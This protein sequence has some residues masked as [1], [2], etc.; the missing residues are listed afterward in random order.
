MTAIDASTRDDA[1]VALARTGDEA[2]F[3]ALM[4]RYKGRV[5]R[6][7]LNSIADPDEALDV[8]QDTFLSAYRALSRYDP[9]RSLATWLAAITLNKCRDRARRRALRA[10]FFGARPIDDLA[11]TL[12]AGDA[13]PARS[14]AD[15][16]ELARVRAAMAGLPAALREPLLL[17]TVEEMRHAEAATLLGITPKAV[18]TRIRRARARLNELLER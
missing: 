14:A 7:A 15:R 3:A 18:E 10:F 12:A 16:Q 5:Y 6:L 17:C 8:V 4:Q 9:E 11:D 1:L 2:A 13:D